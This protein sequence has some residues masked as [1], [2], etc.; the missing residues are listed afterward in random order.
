MP[1]RY[2]MEAAVG[3]RQL[4]ATCEWRWRREY[5]PCCSLPLQ[6]NGGWASSPS[7]CPET[8]TSPRIAA[9][10]DNPLPLTWGRG[11]ASCHCLPCNQTWAVFAALLDALGP[12]VAPVALWVYSVFVNGLTFVSQSLNIRYIGEWSDKLITPIDVETAWC[13]K[14]LEVWNLSSSCWKYET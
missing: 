12:R 2:Q 9:M 3:E 13:I 14:V 8:E 11:Y 7:C 5:A 10:A 1:R 6:V 4:L